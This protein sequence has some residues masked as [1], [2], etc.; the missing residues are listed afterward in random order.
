MDY[1]SWLKFLHLDFGCGFLLFRRF[2]EVSCFLGLFFLISLG[3]NQLEFDHGGVLSILRSLF[4]FKCSSTEKSNP[5][6]LSCICGILNFSRKPNR[7][8]IGS[9][10]DA[11]N[12]FDDNEELNVVKL[13]NLVK[14]E[15]DRADLACLELE[16]ERMAAASAAEETMAMIL[17]IQNEKSLV[18]MEAKQYRRLAEEKQLHDKDVIQ[19]LRWIVIK[20]KTETNRL[21]DQLML[22]KQKL[23]ADSEDEEEDQLEGIDESLSFR[24]TSCGDAFEN[25]LLSS[26]ES[27]L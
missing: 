13:R 4:D 26:L 17:R 18:E 2:S 20:Y 23:K 24:G 6:I 19:S 16:K 3:F 5:K 15:K 7:R 11:S 1:D 8:K 12:C 22:M 14:I 27:A 10:D 21:E 9:G 25:G